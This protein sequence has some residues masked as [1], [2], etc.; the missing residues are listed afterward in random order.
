MAGTREEQ[1]VETFVE[2]ADT[3]IDEFDVVDFLHILT[4][5]VTDLVDAAEAGIL[6]ADPHGTLQLMASSSEQTR[7]L[8]LF[9]LQNDQGPC[10]D[11]YRTGQ[12]VIVEDLDAELERWPRFVPEAR[13]DGFAAVHALPLRLR[14]DLIGVLG[15][16]SA[17]PGR[18]SDADISACQGMAHIA[19]ISLLSRRSFGQSRDIIDQLQEALNS[20]IVIEQAKGVL[21][22][23]AGIGPDE[24]FQ[25]LRHY[26]RGHNLRLNDVARDTVHGNLRIE[27]VLASGGRATSP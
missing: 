18:L 13:K 6:L 24:A 12:P 15:V 5:R 10:L 7:A 9:L 27:A 11:C 2:L 17:A 14:Q 20:R 23:R 25:R 4:R 16:F 19:T 8:E 3:L 26:A 21:A 22:E 1:L